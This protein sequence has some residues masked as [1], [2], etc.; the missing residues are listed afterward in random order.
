MA[1]R[2]V[3]AERETRRSTSAAVPQA[4]FLHPLADANPRERWD[5]YT[6]GNSCLTLPLD[7]EA[8]FRQAASRDIDPIDTTLATGVALEAIALRESAARV[9]TD[10]NAREEF[11]LAVYEVL[12]GP[13]AGDRRAWARTMTRM[14]HGAVAVAGLCNPRNQWFLLG[15]EIGYWCQSQR[16]VLL[17]RIDENEQA[18]RDR[19]P[20]EVTEAELLRGYMPPAFAPMFQA[21]ANID[22]S[23]TCGVAPVRRLAATWQQDRSELNLRRVVREYAAAT[24]YDRPSHEVDLQ[25]VRGLEVTLYRVLEDLAAGRSPVPSWDRDASTLRYAGRVIRTYAP[26]ARTVVEILDAFER[27]GWPPT[28]PLPRRNVVVNDAV[29]SLNHGLTEIH[30]RA[31]GTGRG[32]TWQLVTP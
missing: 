19:N 16:R 23:D 4:G 9:P 8:M 17:A 11:D 12:A 25:A 29:R 3:K 22:P 15:M 14:L 30:F 10:P 26:R 6:L 28:V 1:K 27:A 5:L 31:D 32:V 21:A 13:P 18:I 20:D 24:D 7:V 2:R